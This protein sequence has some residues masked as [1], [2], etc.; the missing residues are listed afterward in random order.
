VPVGAYTR[1]ALERLGLGEV[2][3]TNTVSSEPDVTAV[4]SKVRLGTADA[5][6]VYA[7]DWLSTGDAVRR[8]DLPARAL[9]PVRYG[10]CVVERD[11]V[12]RARAG[13]FVR[14]VLGPAGRRELR[15]AGFGVPRLG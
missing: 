6:F 4:L 9:A 15:A 5:G 1:Q 10:L 7:T 3:Q 12:D 2:L 14:S 8:V 11:G 13:R